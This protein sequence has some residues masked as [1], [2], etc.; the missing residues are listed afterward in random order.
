MSTS[1]QTIVLPDIPELLKKDFLDIL[2]PP[3]PA[4]IEDD[5]LIIE[6]VSQPSAVNRTVDALK[7]ISRRTFTAKGAPAYNSTNSAILD[8]FNN[9]SDNTF[10]MD[11]AK[12]L[13]QSWSEDPQLTLRLIW[14]LRS[15]PDGK[16]SREIFYRY[17]YV[18][19]AAL[20]SFI[21]LFP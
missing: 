10:G 15:I 1:A 11:V 17:V 13:S 21:Y 14:T 19:K 18:F 3:A 12:Y 7:E 16:G 5:F 4:S 6:P 20:R 2:L 9:L 8:A